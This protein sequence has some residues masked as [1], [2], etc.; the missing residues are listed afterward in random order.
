MITMDGISEQQKKDIMDGVNALN[1]HDLAKLLSFSADDI[2]GENVA[3]GAANHGKEESRNYFKQLFDAIPDFKIE[4][5]LCFGSGKYRCMEYVV[6]GTPVKELGGIPATGKSFKVRCV[7]VSELR[8]GK[9]SRAS[10]YYDLATMLR[11]LG[12]LPAMSQ[13]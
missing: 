9:T 3:L 4:P 1:A 8:D 11:Q 13:K 5:T 2:I 7:G 10:T 6:S 12:V